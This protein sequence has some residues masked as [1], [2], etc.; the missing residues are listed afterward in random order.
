MTIIKRWIPPIRIHP[1]LLIFI[2]VSFLTGTIMEMAIIFSLVLLHELGHFFAAT[3]YKWRIPLVIL[4]AFGGVMKTDEHGNK[5]IREEL[6]VTIAGPFVHILIYGGLFLVNEFQLLPEALISLIFYYNSMILLFNLIPVWPLDG[7]KLL[8]LLSS[9]LFPFKGA[10]HFTILSSFVM[11]VVVVAVQFLFLP[12]TLSAFFVWAFLFVENWREWKQ[13]FYVFIRFLLHRY[14]GKHIVRSV[15]PLYVSSESTYGEVLSFFHREKKH[16][17]Y[18][19]YP[20]QSRIFL[21]DNECLELYFKENQI[22]G[23]IGDS[24]L[25]KS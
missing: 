25:Y 21:D 10:Y 7:G 5:P 12:F 18:I 13:R 11:I 9:Y 23:R 2:I 1:I 24:F 20:D 15:K 16:P 6:V 3:Y 17:I 8:L 22:K 19:K 14:E 4:W